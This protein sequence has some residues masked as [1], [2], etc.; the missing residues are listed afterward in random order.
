MS[1]QMQSPRE[2]VENMT[3]EE[4]DRLLRKVARKTDDDRIA[5]MCRIGV[6]ASPSDKE[7]NAV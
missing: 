5:E 1:S 4:K 2:M 6:Q 3:E 7:D